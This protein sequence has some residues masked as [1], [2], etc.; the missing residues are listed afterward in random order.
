MGKASV[1]QESSIFH[2]RRLKKFYKKREHVKIR[3]DE[4]GSGTVKGYFAMIN[5]M[6][7]DCCHLWRFRN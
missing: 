3:I 1:I 4:G 2:L 6:E 5:T 7:R